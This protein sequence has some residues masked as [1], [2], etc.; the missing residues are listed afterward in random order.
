MWLPWLPKSVGHIVFECLLV[1]EAKRMRADQAVEQ[2]EAL[3]HT[4]RQLQAFCSEYGIE[5]DPLPAHPISS[6]V[7]LCGAFCARTCG[8]SMGLGGNTRPCANFVPPP[9]PSVPWRRGCCIED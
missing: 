1:E 3:L 5:L 2:L 9:S 4:E 6:R 8:L 7:R